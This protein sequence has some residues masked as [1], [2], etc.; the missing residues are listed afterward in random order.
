M[1][2]RRMQVGDRNA[3]AF[4]RCF[5][6]MALLLLAGCKS[7][8]STKEFSL[9]EG[10]PQSYLVS[11]SAERAWAAVIEEVDSIS[12]KKVLASE[13]DAKLISWV[14]RATVNDA[15][16]VHLD[17]LSYRKRRKF[18]TRNMNVVRVEEVE[19]EVARI[20]VRQV[21]HLFHKKKPVTTLGRSTGQYEKRFIAGVRRRLALM[22]PTETVQ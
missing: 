20:Y 7:A 19:N 8:R 14:H 15:S 21:H 13:P 11:S 22:S 18:Y 9:H 16:K 1:M 12:N 4:A 3:I 6:C 17:H 5:I 2:N 10:Q